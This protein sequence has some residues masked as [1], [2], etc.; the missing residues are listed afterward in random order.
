VGGYKCTSD[1]TLPQFKQAID[2]FVA[3]GGDRSIVVAAF[4]VK[5]EYLEASFD[6]MQKQYGKIERYFSEA[7]GIHAAEQKASERK[8]K[9]TNKAP[10]ILFLEVEDGVQT[11]G[12]KVN[13]VGEGMSNMVITATIPDTKGV[14]M[15]LDKNRE[16]ELAVRI[17]T[18]VCQAFNQDCQLSER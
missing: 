9:I 4:G 5:P 6:E 18:S 13:K 14:S 12:I 2:D 15:E 16:K 10:E 8:I 11:A 1:Y 17:A 7:L 3:A